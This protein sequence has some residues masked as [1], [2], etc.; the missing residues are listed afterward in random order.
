MWATGKTGISGSGKRY[1]WLNCGPCFVLG[2][3][4]SPYQLLPGV[5]TLTFGAGIHQQLSVTCSLFWATCWRA[6]PLGTPLW[7]SPVFVSQI[8][9]TTLSPSCTGS[10]VGK[11]QGNFAHFHFNTTEMWN[12]AGTQRMRAAAAGGHGHILTECPPVFWGS[13]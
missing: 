4:H 1:S 6:F 10:P 12:H 11:D 3:K 2:S 8:C 7:P 9:P 13:A 5:R